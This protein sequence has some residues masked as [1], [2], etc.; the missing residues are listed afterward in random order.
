MRY[1][2]IGRLPLFDPPL[3]GRQP[4]NFT[5]TGAVPAMIC[6]WQHVQTEKIPRCRCTAHRASRHLV[7][8]DARTG[9][10]LIVV[11]AVIENQLATARLKA[12]QVQVLGIPQVLGQC[13]PRWIAV[14]VELEP[15]IGRAR[16]IEER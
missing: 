7:V 16:G 5:A 11:P 8:V 13:E 3:E 14:V 9:R 4:V 15:G 12:A 2:E 10:N 6:G 1:D